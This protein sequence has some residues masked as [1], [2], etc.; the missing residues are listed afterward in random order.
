[1]L[2]FSPSYFSQALLNSKTMVFIFLSFFSPSYFSQALL[3][4]KTMVFIFLFEK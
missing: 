4:S 3:N 1:L 2:L